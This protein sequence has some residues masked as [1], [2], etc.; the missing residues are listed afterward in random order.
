MVNTYVPFYAEK[1]NNFCL[2]VSYREENQIST[3]K[4]IDPLTGPEAHDL[5]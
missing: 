1:F 2:F 3:K 5:V 4:G